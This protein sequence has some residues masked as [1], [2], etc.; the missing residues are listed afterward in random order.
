M[1]EKISN[2]MSKSISEDNFQMISKIENNKDILGDELYIYFHLIRS[3]YY[4]I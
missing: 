2:D 1:L 4:K 3:D